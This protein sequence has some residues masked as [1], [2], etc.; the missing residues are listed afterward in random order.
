V[1]NP[2]T[3]N[4]PGGVETVT[5]DLADA[6][7]LAQL[8][9]G[10]D[11]VVHLAG[12][13]TGL[14]REDYFK[15]NE[16]GTLALAQAAEAARVGRFVHVSSLAARQPQLS[17]YA[18]SKRAGEEVV[19]ARAAALNAVIIRPPAVYGPGDRGTLPLIK[20]LTNPVAMIP[21]R[22]E[23]RFS[24][25]HGRDLARLIALAL[26]EGG[27][28]LYEVSD[29]RAGGYGWPD[30]LAVA[31]ALRGSTIPPVFLPRAVPA[32]VA[33]VADVVSRLRR[34]P[35]MINSGKIAELYFPDWVA[36]PGGLALADPI[37]FDRGFPETVNWYRQAGW[38]PQAPVADRRAPSSRTTQ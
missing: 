23:A 29:G 1:R 34:R 30:L 12:A 37:T 32:A 25:I 19:K 26:G 36:A 20:E 35:S 21:G 15:V 4:L 38:L 16:Q 27:Q 6:E 8:V 14:R 13:L 11:A 28:S 22:A 31:S 33:A 3:A 18:A 5:G 24:L 9:A 7:A 17:A 2:A 10:A